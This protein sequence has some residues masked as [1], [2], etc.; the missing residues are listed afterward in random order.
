[1]LVLR[2]LGSGGLQLG[3]LNGCLGDTA[4]QAPLAEGYCWIDGAWHWRPAAQCPT[5]LVA[6]GPPLTA[7]SGY[8]WIRKNPPDM[9][10]GYWQRAPA[11]DGCQFVAPPSPPTVSAGWC[12]NTTTGQWEWR[13]QTQCSEPVQATTDTREHTTATPGGGVTVTEIKEQLD[14][15]NGTFATAALVKRLEEL[16]WKRYLEREKM[17]LE[18]WTKTLAPCPPQSIQPPACKGCVPGC[19]NWSPTTMAQTVPGTFEMLGVPFNV[20]EPGLTKSP[21]FE[22]TYTPNNEQRIFAEAA[23]IRRS[24][25]RFGNQYVGSDLS[26]NKAL[27]NLPRWAVNVPGMALKPLKPRAEEL[28]GKGGFTAWIKRG[29]FLISLDVIESKDRLNDEATM[30]QACIGQSCRCGDDPAV[31]PLPSCIKIAVPST[32]DIAGGGF[33]WSIKV[34]PAGPFTLSAKHDDPT[35]FERGADKIVSVMTAVVNAACGALPT[36][37]AQMKSVTEEKCLDKAGKPCTKG[38]VDCTCITPSAATVG[39]AGVLTFIAGKFCAG[40]T[41]LQQKPTETFPPVPDP[42]KVPEKRVGWWLVGSAIA[43]AAVGALAALRR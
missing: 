30:P 7:Q 37:Q 43:G 6:G 11:T 9:F 31:H 35:W 16:T 36:V 2:G 27:T 29:G 19:Y 1:M 33:F 42:P 26:F 4:P 3:G 23:I 22:R 14:P 39:G 25:Q 28:D 12:K 15:I 8:C 13:L 40:W 21:K 38:A 41:G 34:D 32:N 5:P 10:P 18:A 20:A 24:I 17:L